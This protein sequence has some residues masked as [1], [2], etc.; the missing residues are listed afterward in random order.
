VPYENVTGRE[1]A[2]TA[3]YLAGG[4][5]LIVTAAIFL[6][7][8]NRVIGVIL[9]FILIGVVLAALVSW[10]T[11]TYAYQCKQCGE[12]FEI[13]PVTNF[14]SPQGVG[15]DGAWKYLKCPHCNKQE[16]AEVLKKVK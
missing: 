9:W 5:L 3:L 11:K 4:M 10:H 6:F 14:I 13:S 12:Q 7:A 16:R 15:K 2:R 8:I 1:W